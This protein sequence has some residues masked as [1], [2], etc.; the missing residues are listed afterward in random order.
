V[1]E[2][3]RSVAPDAWRR[4]LD[5]IVAGLAPGETPLEH[6]PLPPAVLDRVVARLSG[7]G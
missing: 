6:E 2:T 1:I 4:H 7:R 3:T 5:I